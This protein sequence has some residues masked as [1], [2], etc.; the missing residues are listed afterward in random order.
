MKKKLLVLAGPTAIGKT[1]WAIQLAQ[2]LG[3]SI[4]SSDSRQCYLELGVAVAK[5]SVSELNIVPHYFIN[6]HSIFKTV[7]AADYA[8]YGRHA[9]EE[10]FQT[11]DWAVVCGGT[12]LYLKALLEGMD[13]IPETEPGIRNTIVEAYTNF[14]IE[15]LKSTLM[16]E[17]SE[18]A[19]ERGL[20]NPQRMMRALEVKRSTGQSIRTF[21]QKKTNL[22][23]YEIYRFGMEMP[24][25]LLNARINQRVDL[26][27]V[28]G[29][30]EEAKLLYE[31]RSLNALQ[32][33]GYQEVFEFIDGKVDWKEAVKQIKIHTHQYAKRQ[34]T[35]FKRDNSMI[36]VDAR[37]GIEQILD[38][39]VS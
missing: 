7:S 33:V 38:K 10:I 11:S 9:L 4:L 5:P 8:V 28:S 13:E 1:S 23:P 32:T 3:T 20:E 14:G 35:W 6:S 18:Y 34:M 31:H 12:G 26:M 22:L 29:L 27:V 2:H 17:D 19:I 39:I 30:L 15:W 24:R 16:K 25:D 37:N 21:Q 36:W